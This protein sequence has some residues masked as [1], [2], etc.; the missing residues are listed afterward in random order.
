MTDH[1]QSL[2]HSSVEPFYRTPPGL[3]AALDREFG[4]K[5]D[6]AADRVSSLCNHWYGPQA[7]HGFEDG[8][9]CRWDPERAHF[10]NPPYSRKRM[11]ELRKLGA[12]QTEINAFDISKWAEKCATEGVRVTIVALL[13]AAIQTQWWQQCVWEHA[14][15]IRFIPHR[16]TFLK[17]S[18]EACENV[19]GVN[20]AVVIWKPDPGY[21]GQWQPTVRYW[22]YL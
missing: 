8:L 12:R 19:A 9:R 16:I 13:P 1:A 20:H 10:C 7:P 14:D 2:I 6:A 17:P 11:A 22:D 21:V 18:G 4:L 5:V 15:E 3:F